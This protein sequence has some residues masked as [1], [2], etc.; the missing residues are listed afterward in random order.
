MTSS[1]RVISRIICFDFI[2]PCRFVYV[3]VFPILLIL[4]HGCGAII[5]LFVP[6]F[7]DGSRGF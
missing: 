1:S 7:R 2:V 5:V 6:C 4:L 3:F